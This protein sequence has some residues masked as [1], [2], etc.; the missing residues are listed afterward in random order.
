MNKIRVQRFCKRAFDQQT[1]PLLSA[2]PFCGFCCAC[3]C[4]HAKK[5]KIQSRREENNNS[6]QYA[7]QI[8][9][10]A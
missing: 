7:F 1:Q 4:G 5:E 10:S 8:L 2:K 9:R 3:M 6:L